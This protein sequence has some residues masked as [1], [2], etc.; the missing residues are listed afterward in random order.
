MKK[1][2]VTLPLLLCIAF[3]VVGQ[4]IIDSIN[5]PC[6][7][8]IIK[9]TVV[10]N[11]NTIDYTTSD[12]NTVWDFS[13][14]DG[15][16]SVSDTFIGVLSTPITYIATFSNPFDQPH[17][18]TVAAKQPAI[19]SLPGITISNMYN[20]YK[21]TNSFYGQVGFG[22]EINNVPL[23]VKYD[24]AEKILCFPLLFGNID[25]SFSKYAVNIPS[26]GY[27]AQR[28]HRTNYVDGW[29]TLYLPG[30]TFD[31]VRV[32]STIQIFD[33]I[34]VDSLGF[35]IGFNR[36]EYEYKW[37]STESKLAVF[38][39]NKRSGG[40][41]GIGTEAW[42]L[43]NRTDIGIT[44]YNEKPSIKLFPNPVEN[45]LMIDG[46]DISG[47]YWKISDLSGR[48][49]CEGKYQTSQG[50]DISKI[51]SGL[52]LIEIMQSGISNTLRFI[53]Q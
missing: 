37:I 53:K 38:Q 50:I 40:M 36:N 49:L 17:K 45:R 1:I 3:T 25:S 48:I 15:T 13:M 19:P 22:A 20:F 2:L 30:D 24:N 27:N 31:V 11:L 7:G 42:F 23:P 18:A 21:A 44:D 16:S 32:R 9:R 34:Y 29:G 39:V 43:D 33:S 52:Y 46:T 47:A 8:E 51:K 41:G 26:L 12:S 14:L 6:P 5:M 28:R 35:G 10:N 4:T